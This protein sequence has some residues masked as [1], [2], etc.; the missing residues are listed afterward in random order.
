MGEDCDPPEPEVIGVN[1]QS[2]PIVPF[3]VVARSEEL[4]T[5]ALSLIEM[6]TVR[7]SPTWA[8]R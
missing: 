2:K 6:L 4:P 3:E 8:M 5:T 7:M 1:S